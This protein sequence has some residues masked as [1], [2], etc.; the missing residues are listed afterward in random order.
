MLYSG[1]LIGN[2]R[3][4]YKITLGKLASGLCT[5][6]MLTRI[7]KGE[8]NV[9]KLLFESLYQR[10]GKYSDRF[11]ILLDAVEYKKLEKR[12]EICNLIDK[13]KYTMAQIKINQY[14]AETNNRLHLQY[15]CLVECEIMHR[16]Y[17]DVFECKNK[18]IE[19]LRC[20]I[21]NF[22]I[23]NVESYYL[24]RMEMMM[25]QQ[26]ARY[27]ELSGE[28]NLA[29]KLYHRILEKLEEK[30]YDRS[31]RELL[32]RSVGYWLM[33]HYMSIG[34]YE[35]A[36][37]VG[38]RAYEQTVRG[39]FIVFLAE[40]KEG[41][42]ECNEWL[43][44]DMAAERKKLNILKRMNEKIGVM[45]AVNYFPRYVEER[46]YN[47][48]EVISQRRKLLGLTQEELAWGVCDV[49][50]VS[51]LEN[52]RT[53]LQRKYRE[54]LLQR[55]KMSGDK[56]IAYVDTYEYRIFEKL[57]QIREAINAG[58]TD[59]AQKIINTL[60]ERGKLDT[61]NSTNYIF[62]VNEKICLL[63]NGKYSKT[64]EEM[65]KILKRGIGV[66]GTEGLKKVILLEN[67]WRIVDMI[68]SKYRE[69]GLRSKSISYLLSVSDA[70]VSKDIYHN[71]FRYVSIKSLLGNILGEMRLVE[72]ANAY[73][74]E[75]LRMCAKIDLLS[76]IRSLTYDYAWN[77]L[78]KKGKI[79]REDKKK[80]KEM[81]E[82]AY[83]AS[84]IYNNV[85]KKEKIKKI[86]AKHEI[87]LDVDN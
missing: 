2:I 75:A 81:L 31:E 12:W 73:L 65:K 9:E 87:V 18:L 74:D 16:T 13:K 84:D 1:L 67:E 45:K 8:R 6:S 38:T 32:S 39:D 59:M 61:I 71:G 28:G 4:E 50:T 76:Y 85:R 17:T 11:E 56:Y 41:I 47:V 7:E 3:K 69:I 40:L 80:G 64:V 53:N 54:T 83:V 37:E 42:I 19:G 77:I 68:V 58:E 43:G 26:Y 27:V 36:L 66:S 10:L 29:A 14:K 46:A 86:C 15:M 72:A 52:K 44:K 78:E 21:K 49:K 63:K 48:N 24:S 82:Y 35:K 30:R 51:R 33:K 34:E 23:D 5:P 25:V 62:T 79:S 55:V 57:N 20:T 70:S 22:C 60:T